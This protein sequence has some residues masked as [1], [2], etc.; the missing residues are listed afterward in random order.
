[1][2]LVLPSSSLPPEE[3]ERRS[4]YVNGLGDV[5]VH[6]EATPQGGDKPCHVRTYLFLVYRELDVGNFK[7]LCEKEGA[8][9]CAVVVVPGW[10]MWGHA[11]GHEHA[12]VYQHTRELEMEI[13]T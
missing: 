4:S 13:L 5:R 6:R 11:F 2:G 8:H 7:R 9:V 1:M 3:E 10:N 12:I